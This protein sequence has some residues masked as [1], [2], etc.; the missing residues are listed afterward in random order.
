M[1][2]A[3]TI[4][5]TWFL[6][7]AN[8]TRIGTGPNDRIYEFL[9]PT[10]SQIRLLRIDSLEVPKNL[11]QDSSPILHCSLVVVSLDDTP[12]YDAISYV[13]GDPNPQETIFVNSQSVQ[14]GE[15]LF[16]ALRCQY[17]WQN[18]TRKYLWADALC[19]DQ[20]NIAERSHQVSMMRDIYSRAQ[21]VRICLGMA[22]PQ[23]G[24]FFEYAA[25]DAPVAS[26]FTNSDGR[27]DGYKHVI[28]KPWWRRLW[29]VQEA[30]L[31]S[32]AVV[33]CGEF[34]VPFATLFT[35]I[36]ELSQQIALQRLSRNQIEALGDWC[37]LYSAL[38]FDYSPWLNGTGVPHSLD[39]I[40]QLFRELG[41]FE[42]T[43]PKDRLYGAL[44][45]LPK[46][47]DMRADYDL[48][49]AQTDESLMVR[50]I[51]WTKSLSPL[52]YSGIDSKDELWPSWLSISR[53]AI[54]SVGGLGMYNSSLWSKFHGPVI[55]DDRMLVPAFI[56]DEVSVDGVKR[57]RF[58]LD[59]W[60]NGHGIESMR[61]ILQRWRSMIPEQSFLHLTE[62]SAS[63][64][65]WSALRGLASPVTV[66]LPEQK[67]PQEIRDLAAELD[68]WLDGTVVIPSA[69]AK[70]RLEEACALFE[71][72]IWTTK[73]G[74][75][76]R[77][78]PQAKV[79]D[80]VAIIYSC[81]LPLILRPEADGKAKTYRI[82][83]S[84]FCEGLCSDEVNDADC[85]LTLFHRCHVRRMYSGAG[86]TCRC[87]I[88]ITSG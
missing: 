31:A 3:W 73:S 82:I 9:D 7:I 38:V 18:G 37:I 51:E 53:R 19:I 60:D 74:R 25:S 35:L 41:E 62:E 8:R 34:T 83:S 88:L 45:L 70:S 48:S 65:F 32:Q 72:H 47:L 22:I 85:V 1:S 58:S 5:K 11:G 13:W 21:V 12:E 54:N 14:I 29:V 44:G 61:A 20:Q 68:L 56:F 78:V 55:S 87:S 69:L 15:N 67:A 49:L 27:L 76:A 33:H 17:Y 71:N 10:K 84:C 43:N 52:A 63:V 42:V 75:I 80:V 28:S 40:V 64:R 2:S 46:E 79:R 77:S 30:A 57:P 86:Q 4:T 39:E 36:L 66:T 59:T 6:T 24:A 81:S 50:V 26:L 23:V 16:E